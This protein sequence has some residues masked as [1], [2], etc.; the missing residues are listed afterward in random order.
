MDGVT[1]SHAH[2]A[3][4]AVGRLAFLYEDLL[5]GRG[6]SSGLSKMGQCVMLGRRKG[7]SQRIVEV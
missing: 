1:W 5:A 3:V 2:G 6:A 4:G 7:T